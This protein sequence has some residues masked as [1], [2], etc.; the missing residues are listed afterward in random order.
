MY[1]YRITVE[2]LSPN[3]VADQLSFEADNHDDIFAIVERM[4][5]NLD[6]DDDTTASFAVGLKLFSE[7]VLKHRNRA[8]FDAIRPAMKEFMPVLKAHLQAAREAQQSDE[9]PDEAQQT[10]K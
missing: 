9:E 10:E 8:P 6:L 4:R 2:S 3:T 5:G 1:R 7:V